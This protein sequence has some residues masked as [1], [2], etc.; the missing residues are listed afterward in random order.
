MNNPFYPYECQFNNEERRK[1]IAKTIRTLREGKDISQKEIS[2][3]L[4]IK[5]STYSNYENCRSDIP[6]ELLV[7]LSYFFDVP[8]DFIMQ[9]NVFDKEERGIEDTLK[10]QE[11]QL[12]KAFQELLAKGI[13]AE[14]AGKI[15]NPLKELNEFAKELAKSQ[16]AEE[17]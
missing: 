2:A 14:T 15:I 8:L 5:P 4:G 17:K 3:I 7:R 9:R 1:L 13:D 11:E 16:Q 10:E 6:H 12:K